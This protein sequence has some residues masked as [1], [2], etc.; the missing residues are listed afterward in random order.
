MKIKSANKLPV[1]TIVE[2][3]ED[4]KHY[5]VVKCD[6]IGVM[7]AENFGL[8]LEEVVTKRLK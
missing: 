1:G 5:K 8:T 2:L 4:G 7:D 6:R 3:E